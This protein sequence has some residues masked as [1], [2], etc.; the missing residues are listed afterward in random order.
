LDQC[1]DVFVEEDFDK[2]FEFGNDNVFDNVFDLSKSSTSQ[3]SMLFNIFRGGSQFENLDGSLV[4]GVVKN[5]VVDGGNGDSV[6]AKMCNITCSNTF[7]LFIFLLSN[8]GLLSTDK[9]LKFYKNNKFKPRAR[10]KLFFNIDNKAGTKISL[11]LVKNTFVMAHYNAADLSILSDFNDLKKQLSVVNKSFVSLGKPLRFKECFVYIRDTMLLA[12]AGKNKLHDLS[13]LYNSDGKSDFEKRQVSVNDLNNMRV[14]YEREPERFKDYAIQDAIITLKHAVA[15]EEFNMKVYQIGVPI[16]LS[17]IGRKYVLKEWGSIFQKHLPYQVSGEYLMGNADEI[18]T[19]KGLFATRNIGTHMSYYIANYKGGRNESFMYGVD[20]NT[21][22]IDY[23]LT[24]AYTTGMADLALPDYFNAE[25]IK[26]N[27]LDKWTPQQFLKGYLIVNAHFNFPKNVKYP[28]IPCYIDKTTTV[29]PLNGDNAF[30]TGP[31]YWLA[32]Q[33]GC[34]FKII[35]AFY[36]HPKTSTTYIAGEKTEVITKPF[37][38]IFKDIQAKRREY[39]KGTLYNLLY[40][41]MGN[42]IYGNVVRGISNKMNFDTLT[43]KMFRVTGTELSNPILASWSTAFIRS[44]IGECLHNIQKLG[45]MVV[46]VT[47]DGFITNIKNL[48][49]RLLELPEKDIIL[50]NKYRSLR[51]GLTDIKGVKPTKDALEIKTE[52]EGVISWTTRGQKGINSK[53]VATTGFQKGGYNDNELVEIFKNTL[54][55]SDKVFEYTRKTLRSAKDI[56]DKGGHVT[57]ILKDQNF[58][59]IHDN[60]REIIQNGLVK[61]S[62]DLSNIILDSKPLL[63]MD[64][65]KTLRFLSKFPFTAPYNKNN[66]NRAQTRYKT[67]IELGVRNFIKAYYS[68]NEK[69]GLKGNE[70]KFSTNLIAFINGI[71]STKALKLSVSSISRLKSRKLIWRP[72]PPTPENITFCEKIKLKYPYFRDDLFLKTQP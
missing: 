35:S 39:P 34:E 1:K 37:F 41:E 22:W 52:G 72:V 8:M 44:V 69:F 42:S 26:G 30:L 20:E 46:S 15:M 24:S 23:D 63:D 53:I 9:I 19:P 11:T 36:I 56:F 27:D 28:S 21:H 49:E 6:M 2:F 38:E 29:Y 13:K 67:H 50:L 54:K 14:F 31:E 57:P 45:G 4:G 60:R 32:K 7:K 43:G 59:L 18:Q 5:D 58:R 62:V 47:T 64:H 71:V 65:C 70:F 48:E 10:T 3:K 68:T 16:T 66:T 40:K 61:G 12:P 17:S 33:Q 51:E 55:R 25:L